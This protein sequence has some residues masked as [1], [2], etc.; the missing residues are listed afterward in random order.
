MIQFSARNSILRIFV[1]GSNLA[2]VNTDHSN[3][4]LLQLSTIPGM[5]LLSTSHWNEQFI[6]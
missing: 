2:Q 3:F 6:L 5:K 4:G 1:G